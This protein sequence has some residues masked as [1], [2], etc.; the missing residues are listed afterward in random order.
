MGNAVNSAVMATKTP[1]NDNSAASSDS[2][3]QFLQKWLRRHGSLMW[4][5][6]LWRALG[7][8]SLRSFQRAAQEGRT[9]VPVFPRPIGK[10][11]C[12]KTESVARWAY[13]EQQKKKGGVR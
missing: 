1:S 7:Y 9:P 3:E 13:R 4:G 12:A 6:A 2:E 5:E 11:S 8:G 10:G